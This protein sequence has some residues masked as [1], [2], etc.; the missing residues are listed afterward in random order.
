[1]ATITL[2]FG[3]QPILFGLVSAEHVSVAINFLII[4]A[5]NH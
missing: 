4:F 1:L 3:R 5:A 2:G